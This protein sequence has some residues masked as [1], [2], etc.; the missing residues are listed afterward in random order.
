MS[1]EKEVERAYLEHKE[2]S[3][4][5][6]YEERGAWN[7]SKLGY[8]LNGWKVVFRLYWLWKWAEIWLFN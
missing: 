8:R 7:E 3:G 1:T 6:R 4:L 2:N 5:K